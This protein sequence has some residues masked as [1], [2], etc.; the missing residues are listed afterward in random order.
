MNLAT[1]V[2]NRRNLREPF[3]RIAGLTIGFERKTAASYSG[4]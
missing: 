4:Q 3:K 1:G 2:K